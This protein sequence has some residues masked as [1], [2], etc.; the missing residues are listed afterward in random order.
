MNY[1][2]EIRRNGSSSRS[3]W[4]STK[5][6][7][8]PRSSSPHIG[9]IRTGIMPHVTV[10]LR[11]DILPK[12][13]KMNHETAMMLVK[14]LVTLMIQMIMMLQTLA[15]RYLAW[16]SRPRLHLTGFTCALKVLESPWKSLNFRIKIQGLKSP[17]KLQS[18]LESP[19]NLVLPILSNKASQV[20]ETK[21]SAL[22]TLSIWCSIIWA[23]FCPSWVLKKWKNVSLRGLEKSLNFWSKKEYE[24]WPYI[25]VFFFFFSH[26]R[27]CN[28]DQ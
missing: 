19:W 1:C 23:W 3:H 21:L 25:L 18:V 2:V 14:P 6:L 10:P 11:L 26:F 20:F 13:F 17:W 9:H 24:P 27:T 16:D 12:P 28:L 7:Q 22:S 4:R 8:T 15:G 5:L